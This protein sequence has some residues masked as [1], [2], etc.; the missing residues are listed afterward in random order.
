MP[1]LCVL[2]DTPIT[3][4]ER[5]ASGRI[6]GPQR[7]QTRKH[8]VSSLNFFVINKLYSRLLLYTVYMYLL[9]YSTILAI[10]YDFMLLYVIHIGIYSEIIFDVL[11]WECAQ[12]RVCA[13]TRGQRCVLWLIITAF[14]L[15][16][17][18]CDLF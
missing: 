8:Q 13:I 7:I 3:E 6:F 15:C 11:W 1:R 9:L 16:L 4:E 5:K 2:D 17:V 10:Q 14:P 12:V 18:S